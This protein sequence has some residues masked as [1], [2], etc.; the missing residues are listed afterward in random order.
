MD[1]P[2]TKGTAQTKGMEEGQSGGDGGEEESKGEFS[3]D[4]PHD[5]IRNAVTRLLQQLIRECS[6]DGE[7]QLQAGAQ[8]PTAGRS[9]KQAD[10]SSDAA[11]ARLLSNG[12]VLLDKRETFQAL[13][14]EWQEKRRFCDVPLHAIAECYGHMGGG[15][16]V[17]KALHDYTPLPKDVTQIVARYCHEQGDSDAAIL[18]Q[19][20]S[21][22]IWD[23]ALGAGL[24]WLF[25]NL[26]K[27]DFLTA[28]RTVEV[29]KS[30]GCHVK[31][32]QQNTNQN[33]PPE[34]YSMRWVLVI[35]HSGA[36]DLYT[37]AIRSFNSSTRLLVHKLTNMP[38]PPVV[39]T[40]LT[41]TNE[42]KKKKAKKLT[43]CV[44]HHQCLSGKTIRDIAVKL[45]SQFDAR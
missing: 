28:Y 13:L 15:R 7:K 4:S 10:T 5:F 19:D 12:Q 42:R 3:D 1:R 43:A 37:K 34:A 25:R 20:S 29:I 21:S 27:R 14:K 6:D 40:H 24:K 30:P 31:N 8:R 39:L 33:Q 38:S 2:Y 32:P 35:L 26:R 17:L 44:V 22:G 23:R 41:T 11:L 16:A 36:E 18:L 9:K 45:A